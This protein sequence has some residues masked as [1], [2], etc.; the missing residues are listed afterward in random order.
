MTHQQRALALALY[1]YGTARAAR[2]LHNSDE[3]TARIDVAFSAVLDLFAAVAAPL[4]ARIAELESELL[5]EKNVNDQLARRAEVSEAGYRVLAGQVAALRAKLVYIKRTNDEASD[6]AINHY[7]M[8]ELLAHTAAAAQ[9]RDA[10]VERM[11]LERQAKSL[12]SALEGESYFEREAQRLRE[13]VAVHHPPEINEGEATCF[14]CNAA[15]HLAPAAFHARALA[16]R[17]P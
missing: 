3:N 7:G 8:D 1:D 12:V 13:L 10:E 4:E 5:D 9:A 14:L 15:T 11:A 17:K 6:P 16:E 2:A